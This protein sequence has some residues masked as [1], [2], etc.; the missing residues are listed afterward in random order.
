MADAAD[1]RAAEA[2]ADTAHGAVDAHGAAAA[3]A[4]GGEHAATFPPFDSSLFASQLIWFAITFGVLYYIVSRHI[5]PGVERVLEK[6]AATLAADREGAAAKTA[7]AE[8]ARATTERAVAKARADARKLVDDMRADVTAQLTAEQAGAE[9]RLADRIA[10]A[11]TRVNDARAKALA[12]LPGIADTL[13]RDIAGKLV[14][15]S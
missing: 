8:E 2:G 14:P 7:L 4:H 15:A 12:E 9:Q 6:R 5:L 3:G 10:Q 11:E 13:A 1:T